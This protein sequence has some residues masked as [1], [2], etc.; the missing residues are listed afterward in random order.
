MTEKRKTDNV[1]QLPLTEDLFFE[2]I[3]TKFP[4]ANWPAGWNI[5]DDTDAR[6]AASWLIHLLQ[7]LNSFL[8]EKGEKQKNLNLS[9]VPKSTKPTIKTTRREQVQAMKDLEYTETEDKK[10]DRLKDKKV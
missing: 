2:F 8:L 9:R 5:H 4:Y 6:L 1:A 10:L 7:E 3:R